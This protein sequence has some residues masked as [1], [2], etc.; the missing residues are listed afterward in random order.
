MELA[1][2]VVE[3]KVINSFSFWNTNHENIYTSHKIEVY[4]VFKGTLSTNEILL[5]TEGGTVGNDMEVASSLL[6]LS[7]GEVGIFICRPSKVML[8]DGVYEKNTTP[9]EVVAGKQGFIKYD[10]NTLSAT[11]IFNDYKNVFNDVYKIVLDQT[12]VNYKIVKSVDFIRSDDEKIANK[13]LNS[14]TIGSFSPLS[15]PAGTGDRLTISGSGFGNTRGTGKVGFKNADDGGKTI[16]Y[17]HP[18]QYK[19]WTD[20][21]IVVELPDSAGTGPIFVSNSSGFMDSSLTILTVPFSRSILFYD[22]EIKYPQLVDKEGSGG[23]VFQMNQDFDANNDA[24]TAFLN[25]LLTW[26]CATLV[27]WSMGA[28]TFLNKNAND[29][30]NVVS[31]D[32]HDKL[33]E[34]VLGVC[35][36]YYSACNSDGKWYVSGYD[37]IFRDTTIWHYGPSG[38]INKQQYDLESV[39]LHELGH[40]QQLKH[41]IDKT[42]LMHYSLG[43]GVVKRTLNDNNLKGAN[44]VLAMS[45][46]QGA[47]TYFPMQLLNSAICKDPDLAFFKFRLDVNP[48]PF[49]SLTNISYLLETEAHVTIDIY[50]I[51]GQRVVHLIDEMQSVGKHTYSLEAAQYVMKKGVYILK[52]EVDGNKYSQKL[53]SLQ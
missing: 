15:V 18:V 37:V 48:N 35:F 8:P 14:L 17:S 5:I 44:T 40:G 27:N 3:G 28:T 7:E 23:Y 41:V 21:Q 39:A 6:S 20:N 36:S 34:G 30:I 24:K 11:D 31:F 9:M 49:I 32:T 43:R 50:T 12:K 10:L 13:N 42:D 2:H 46:R 16:S 29:N 45:T 22:G 52:L 26:R 47:C 25:S 38:S 53:V 19:S 51:L 4:K 33:Q 1:T